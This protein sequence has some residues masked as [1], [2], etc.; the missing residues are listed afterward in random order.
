MWNLVLDGNPG[1]HLGGCGNGRGLVTLDTATGE[2]IREP[3]YYAFAHASRFVRP[4]AVRISSESGKG[5][6][7]ALEHVAF[8][9]AGS[10]E[11]VLIV[12]KSVEVPRRL[13]IT[14]GRTSCR[15]RS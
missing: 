15:E 10:V 6:E 12:R 4:G 1:P 3:E 8:R 9:Q 14:I 5:D 13:R 11:L 7:E 2:L